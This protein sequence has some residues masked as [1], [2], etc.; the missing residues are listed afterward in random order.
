M[1]KLMLLASICQSSLQLILLLSRPSHRV[2]C[3][4]LARETAFALL[5]VS[6]CLRTCSTTSFLRSD[7]VALLNVGLLAARPKPPLPCWIFPTMSWCL[8]ADVA[9]CTALDDVHF[10]PACT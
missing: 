9:C 4:C 6:S 3:P 8:R 7:V 2:H 10:R 1:M 5:A